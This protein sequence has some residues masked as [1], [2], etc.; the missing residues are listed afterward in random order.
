MQ[1]NIFPGSLPKLLLCA[2]AAAFLKDILASE[3]IL[4]KK[5]LFLPPTRIHDNQ[6]YIYIFPLWHII[7]KLLVVIRQRQT[8]Q[9]M[10]HGQR[11][12]QNWT[13]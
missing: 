10:H 5:K 7:T 13:K 9:A 2:A 1:P 12:S 8:M 4:D 11:T 3:T 6:M